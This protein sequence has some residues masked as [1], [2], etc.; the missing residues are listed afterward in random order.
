[1]CRYIN[2]YGSMGVHG[3]TCETVMRCID[4]LMRTAQYG[5]TCD[6]DA[7]HWCTCGTCGTCVGPLTH[8]LPSIVLYPRPCSHSP[9]ASLSPPHA[10]HTHACTHNTPP[11]IS[12]SLIVVVGLPVGRPHPIGQRCGARLRQHSL[13]RKEGERFLLQALLQRRGRSRRAKV[14]V[15]YDGTTL[16]WVEGLGTPEVG[17]LAGVGH[18]GREVRRSLPKVVTYVQTW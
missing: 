11:R 13:D 14:V 12:K 10:P 6:S 1:M 4:T 2:A 18:G 15:L 17:R 3:G 9:A 5:S 7:V 16:S 8:S